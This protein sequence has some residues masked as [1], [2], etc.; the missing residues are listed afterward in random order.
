MNRNTNVL[1]EK[2]MFGEERKR[3][4]GGGGGVAW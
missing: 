2:G 1:T 3:E 4:K